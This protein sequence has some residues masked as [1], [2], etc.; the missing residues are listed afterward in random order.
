MIWWLRN[1]L[2]EGDQEEIIDERWGDDIDSYARG[3]SVAM[4]GRGRGEYVEDGL[5]ER[6]NERTRKR[7][8][9]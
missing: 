7:T 3:P 6:T 1:D 5:N 4:W 8:N 9:K 2:N